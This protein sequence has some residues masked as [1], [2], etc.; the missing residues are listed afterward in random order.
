MQ[1]QEGGI[2]ARYAER[3]ARDTRVTMCHTRAMRTRETP[4]LPMHDVTLPSDTSFETI[5]IAPDGSYTIVTTLEPVVR[6]IDVAIMAIPWALLALGAAF[7][8]VG[9]V[10]VLFALRRREAEGAAICRKCA[11]PVPEGGVDRCTECGANLQGRR[12]KRTGRSRWRRSVRG[13]AVA[14]VGVGLA[15]LGR[16]PEPVARLFVHPDDG[17]RALYNMGVA[18]GFITPGGPTTPAYVREFSLVVRRLDTVTGEFRIVHASATGS[19]RAFPVFS[20][21]SSRFACVSKERLLVFD[22]ASGVLTDAVDVADV[23][24]APLD[25]AFTDA[26]GF[27][28]DGRSV[29]A[30][31]GDVPPGMSN[32]ADGSA[33]LAE[34]D[35]G[36]GEASTVVEFDLVEAIGPAADRIFPIPGTDDVLFLQFP[37]DHRALNDAVDHDLSWVRL[38]TRSTDTFTDRFPLSISTDDRPSFARDGSAFFV[39]TYILGQA[40]VTIADLDEIRISD[41]VSRFA[42]PVQFSMVASAADDM[43]L[44]VGVSSSTGRRSTQIGAY[45]RGQRSM[46]VLART[47]GIDLVHSVRVSGDGRFLAVQAG[48]GY[49]AHSNAVERVLVYDLREH[50]RV[51]AYLEDRAQR[52]GS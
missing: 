47:P 41:G 26:G 19:L 3:M 25:A 38:Y 14:G 50:P 28:D 48:S 37:S 6:T 1:Q 45:L 43:G 39:P 7:A 46:F 30:V 31:W 35:L 29:Y 23:E 21:D 16:F 24:G 22:G 40:I 13:V 51:R 33:G 32:P 52:E 17:S 49:Y 2:G 11:Y 44:L 20:L 15:V 36:G 9:L 12:S 27:S 5:G 8:F 34:F 10:L 18:R 42:S 4:L